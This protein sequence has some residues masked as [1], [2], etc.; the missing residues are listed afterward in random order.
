MTLLITFIERYESK[1][2]KYRIERII[3]VAQDFI[4]ELTAKSKPPPL[5]VVYNISKK[6]NSKAMPLK[7]FGLGKATCFAGGLLLSTYLAKGFNTSVDTACMLHGQKHYG[8]R[9]DIS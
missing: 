1:Y 3:Q 2:G 8:Q 6:I 4:A 5:K 7:T 9:W